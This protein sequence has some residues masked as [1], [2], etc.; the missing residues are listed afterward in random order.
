MIVDAQFGGIKYRNWELRF[1]RLI[2]L[3]RRF[4][5]ALLHARVASPLID[6]HLWIDDGG[7]EAIAIR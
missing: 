6:L 3:R 5:S 7:V 2:V 4:C 1:L